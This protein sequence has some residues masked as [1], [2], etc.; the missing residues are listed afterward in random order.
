MFGNNKKREDT[1]HLIKRL[2]SYSKIKSN[3]KKL[4]DHNYTLMRDFIKSPF[5]LESRKISGVEKWSFSENSE[6]SK[7]DLSA[8]RVASIIIKYRNA[9]KTLGA[10]NNDFKP[11]LA[12]SKAL[13]MEY[14]VD[15]TLVDALKHSIQV[16]TLVDRLSDIRKQYSKG[17]V[18]PNAELVRGAI[19]SVSIYHPIYYR[20]TKPLS[21]AKSISN[22]KNA[23]ALKAKHDRKIKIN[24]DFL[25]SKARE[26]LNNSHS[27]WVDLAV[28]LS[29]LTGRRPTEIMKTANFKLCKDKENYLIF[30]GILKSR[31]RNLDIDF[32]EW[33]IPVLAEPKLIIQALKT[34]R[35][36]LTLQ[37][38]E[39]EL[40]GG[41]GGYFSGGFLRY[42]NSQGKEVKVS[43][44]DKRYT[45]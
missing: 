33:S 4:S 40:A 22:A 14:G 35:R 25:Y 19:D 16:E 28:A 31:D 27:D 44:S 6:V 36:K 41:K 38:K 45:M 20:F 43:I 23:E 8:S 24:T 42:N 15:K 10:I 29:T 17:S 2:S 11:S 30:N 37:E 3:S 12:K 5:S 13:L 26:V 32:G 21:Y 1:Q 39:Q 18:K 34:M 9:I 7:G